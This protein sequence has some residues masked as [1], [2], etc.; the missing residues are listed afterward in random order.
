LTNT[1]SLIAA[2]SI[3][4]QTDGSLGLR[5]SLQGQSDIVIT[6]L[7]TMQRTRR[8]VGTSD[9]MTSCLSNMIVYWS[10]KGA[11]AI[12]IQTEATITGKVKVVWMT[13]NNVGSLNSIMA[14]V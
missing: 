14:K 13:S 3:K 5:F 6:T 4:I 9:V 10:L 11:S 2:A 12:Q 7:G 8:L 1:R